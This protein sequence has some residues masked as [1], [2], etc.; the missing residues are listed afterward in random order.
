VAKP[1]DIPILRGGMPRSLATL[2]S[3]GSPGRAA[4]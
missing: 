1:I 2:R 4:C 3:A